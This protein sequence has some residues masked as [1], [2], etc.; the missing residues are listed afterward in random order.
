MYI[1]ASKKKSSSENIHHYLGLIIS[2]IFY[3]ALLCPSRN[4]GQVGVE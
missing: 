4:V 1:L 3:L 2:L